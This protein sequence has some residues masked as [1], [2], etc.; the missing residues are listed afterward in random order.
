MKKSLTYRFLLNSHIIFDEKDLTEFYLSKN[1][2]IDATQVKEIL[3]KCF[4]MKLIDKEYDYYTKSSKLLSDPKNMQTKYFMDMLNDPQ[5]IDLSLLKEDF[6]A[7][8]I[9]DCRDSRFY[10][11]AQNEG[12]RIFKILSELSKTYSKVDNYTL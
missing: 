10:D 3:D 7:Y 12:K 1:L 2:K 9:K 11:L 5:Y 8:C 6:I 4:Q